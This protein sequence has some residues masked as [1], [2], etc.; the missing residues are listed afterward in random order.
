MELREC[1]REEVEVGEG[2][3]SDPVIQDALKSFRYFEQLAFEIPTHNKRTLWLN[4]STFSHI[5]VGRI[6]R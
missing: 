2:E 4:W 3:E 1:E 5:I 6:S